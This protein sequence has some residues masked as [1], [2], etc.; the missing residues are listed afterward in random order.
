MGIKIGSKPAES[1]SAGD[2]AVSSPEPEED[3]STYFSKKLGIHFGALDKEA[4]SKYS[5]P[6]DQTGLVITG[7]AD[8]SSAAENGLVEGM[9]LS[10]YKRQSDDSFVKVEDPRKLLA[11]L[12]SLKNGEKIAFK[13][14]FKGR[15]DFI[16]L[17]AEE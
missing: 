1:E 14:F 12:K 10:N 16:A 4:R 7:I 8:G 3:G 17:Q 13:V 5:I 6:N 9:V 2:D 15:T 11:V